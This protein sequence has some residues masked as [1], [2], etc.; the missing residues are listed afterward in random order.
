MFSPTLEVSDI[1]VLTGYVCVKLF[2][3]YW[4]IRP[5]DLQE[6]SK[7]ECGPGLYVT[8][9]LHRCLEKEGTESKTILAVE[10]GMKSQTD[11]NYVS[12]NGILLADKSDVNRHQWRERGYGGVQFGCSDLCVSLDMIRCVYR[13]SLPK[14]LD[15]TTLDW[16][17]LSNLM[18]HMNQPPVLVA[19]ER[20]AE[21]WAEA[22]EGLKF[23]GDREA[24]ATAELCE[25]QWNKKILLKGQNPPCSIQ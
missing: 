2:E 11:T 18:G 6:K 5:S 8:T 3:D 20:T 12:L 25:N 17:A 23:H 7:G 22:L 1:D 21:A 24:Y 13:R 14:D 15:P 19:S 10:I 4:G 16:N 9:D